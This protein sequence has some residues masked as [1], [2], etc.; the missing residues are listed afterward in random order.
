MFAL[1]CLAKSKMIYFHFFKHCPQI[2][3]S[4]EQSKSKNMFSSDG[5]NLEAIC[6]TILICNS[7]TII[8]TQMQTIICNKKETVALKNASECNPFVFLGFF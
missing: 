3:F 7:N 6:N 2:E 4:V 5:C 1:L 8:S